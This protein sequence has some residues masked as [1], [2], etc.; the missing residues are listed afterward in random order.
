MGLP[1]QGTM[2]GTQV[3]SLVWKDPTSCRAAKPLCH[4]YWARAPWILEPTCPRAC[5]LQQEKPPQ[6]EARA[7]QLEKSLCSNE[8]PAEPKTNFKKFYKKE[9]TENFP[10]M[11]KNTNSWGWQRMKRLDSITDSMD[12]SLSKLQEMLKDREAWRAA[13]HGVA[14]RQT[15]LGNW[16]TTT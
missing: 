6:W 9:K 14:K 4:S 10:N 11:V 15:W 3:W 12:I 8:D 16:I 7:P 5:G 2:Q 1:T 13:V